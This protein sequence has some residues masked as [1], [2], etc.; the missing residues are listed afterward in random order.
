MKTSRNKN[1]ELG[2]SAIIVILTVVLMFAYYNRWFSFAA[3]VGPF[4]IIH[5]IA[6]AGTLYIAFGVIVFSYLLHR[7]PQ[8][9]G[10]LLRLHTIG[11]L[12]AFLFISLHFAGQLGRPSNFYPQLGTGLALYIIMLLLVGTGLVLRF[13]RLSPRRNRF[14][15]TGLA[16][17]FYITIIVH[18]LHGLNVI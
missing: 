6:W 7:N 11:N 13:R 17:A 1:W 4:R 12:I 2:L 16:L 14:V 15:H 3:T 18:I 8:K 10:S 5:Y 9:Y